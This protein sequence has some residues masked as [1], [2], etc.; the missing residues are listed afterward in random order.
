MGIARHKRNIKIG[1]KQKCNQ[2]RKLLS[3]INAKKIMILYFSHTNDMQAPAV[4]GLCAYKDLSGLFTSKLEDYSDPNSSVNQSYNG[5][6]FG[7]MKPEPQNM[8]VEDEED[9]LYGESGSSF[10]MKNVSSRFP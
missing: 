5:S 2:Q 6:G 9:L 7:Y 8:K 4:I 3:L 10:K 1:S